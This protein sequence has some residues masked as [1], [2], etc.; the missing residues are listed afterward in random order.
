MAAIDSIAENKDGSQERRICFVS[1]IKIIFY[2]FQAIALP[3]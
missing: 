1:D 3:Q 2:F